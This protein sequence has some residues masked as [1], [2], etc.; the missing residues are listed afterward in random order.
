VERRSTAQPDHSI[1]LERLQ[2]RCTQYSCYLK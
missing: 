1:R 2:K